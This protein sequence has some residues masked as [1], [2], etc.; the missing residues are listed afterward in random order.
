MFKN[1][2]FTALYTALAGIPPS[3]L[4]PITLDV[5]TN[6]YLKVLF[7]RTEIIQ[8]S[9]AKMGGGGGGQQS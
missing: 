4:L 1:M 3:Q 7:T 9:T 6:R 8:I 2:F 5:G